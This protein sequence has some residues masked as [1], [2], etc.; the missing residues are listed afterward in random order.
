VTVKG[1]A[2][3]NKKVV[4]VEVSIDNGIIWHD[5]TGTT[6]WSYRLRLPT[7]GIYTIRSRATDDEGNVELVGG[8]VTV[9]VDNTPPIVSIITELKEIE[10]EN[11][12]DLKGIA[13]DNDL[14][15]KVEIS[16]DGG[17]TWNLIEETGEWT[18]PW[19][20]EDGAYTLQV[21]AYDD[22]QHVGYSDILSVIIDTIPPDLYVTTPSGSVVTGDTF[23]I[24][25][26]VYDV[27]GIIKVEVSV[28]DDP[29]F[30]AQGT[31]SWSYLWVVPA[32]PGEYQIYIRA[33]DTASH[34]T[35]EEITL[36]VEKP[37]ETK[38][39]IS[40]LQLIIIMGVIILC[41]VGASLVYFYFRG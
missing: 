38:I 1:T 31:D 10:P 23:V 9:I 33:W 6:S 3:D 22:L 7:D 35:L 40:K 13:M 4:K 16:T 30:D 20:P 24:T 34:A 37:S 5:A 19:N 21:R 15:R 41:G 36:I 18:Y 17:T 28:G 8:R 32:E 39:G 11:S 14:V 27:N 12:F 2:S 26:T 29:Y 25:G